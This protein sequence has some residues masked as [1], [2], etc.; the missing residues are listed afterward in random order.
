MS[1]PGWLPFL[2]LECQE[3]KSADYTPP[4]LVVKTLRCR[5]GWWLCCREEPLH[6]ERKAARLQLGT[7]G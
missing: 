6:K 2:F 5:G 7:G 4:S 1:R 3:P